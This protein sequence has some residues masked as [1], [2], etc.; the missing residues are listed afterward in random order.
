[1]GV[2]EPADMNEAFAC[3]FN[4]RNLNDLLALYEPNAVLRTGASPGN[5]AGY[6]AIAIELA[7]LL[8]IQGTMRSRNNFCIQLGELALLRA[9]YDV[10]APDGS[11]VASGASCELV[12][13]Q[14]DGRWLYVIDHAAGAGL[15]RVA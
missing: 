9:D 8:Q 1:M 12:R 3:A 11:T 14:A 2:N 13:R 15:P 6:A 7:A 5:H 4:S 10:T